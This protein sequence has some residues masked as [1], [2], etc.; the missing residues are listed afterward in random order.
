MYPPKML[1]SFPRQVNDSYLLGNG[2]I[3]D[4]GSLDPF[5]KTLGFPGQ[6]RFYIC[7]IGNTIFESLIT[8]RFFYLDE[9]EG[10]LFTLNN[11]LT[12]SIV[13]ILNPKYE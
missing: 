3:K 4:Q 2:R 8:K 13:R 12:I 9:F 10:S 1:R 11:I 5:V 6:Q 7:T